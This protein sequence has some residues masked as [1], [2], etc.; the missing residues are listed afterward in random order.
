MIC[1]TDNKYHIIIERKNL[2]LEEEGDFPENLHRVVCVI[3]NKRSL[4][5]LMCF[6]I[7]TAFEKLNT[8]N[9]ISSK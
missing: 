3:I 8:E 4:Q 9:I 7:I 2:K 1:I 6:N 5:S